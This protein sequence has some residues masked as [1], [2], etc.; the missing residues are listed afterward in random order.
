MLGNIHHSKKI[1]FLKALGD[2]I[3][4]LKMED[5]VFFLLLSET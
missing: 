3:D 5:E 2:S 4:F 1:Y